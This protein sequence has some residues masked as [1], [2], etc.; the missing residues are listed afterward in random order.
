MN[1]Y[2]GIAELILADCA[3]TGGTKV[4][5]PPVFRQD[6]DLATALALVPVSE[7]PCQPAKSTLRFGPIIVL[8][9]VAIAAVSCF[10]V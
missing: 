6:T 9:T 1:V 2:S 5:L 7:T 10:L 3:G 8:G 4:D